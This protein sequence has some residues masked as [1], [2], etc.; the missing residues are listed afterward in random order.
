LEDFG[1]KSGSSDNRGK[2]MHPYNSRK[3]VPDGIAEGGR[4]KHPPIRT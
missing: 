1:E 3:E 2:A 4:R